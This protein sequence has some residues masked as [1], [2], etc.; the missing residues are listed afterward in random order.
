MKKIPG[1]KMIYNGKIIF[2]KK[3]NNL[4]YHLKII[5]NNF[6]P[7]PGQFINL[8]I[9]ESFQPFLRKPFSIFNYASNKL[10]IIYKVVGKGTEK[11]CLKKPGEI[12]NFIGPLGN[13]YIDFLNEN[14]LNKY[15]YYLIAG[16]SGIASLN[17]LA[18]WLKRKNINFKLFYGSKT[19]NEIIFYNKYKKIDTKF[20]TDDGSAGYKGLITDL[21][22]KEIKNNLIIFA[23]GPESMLHCLSK[24]NFFKSNIKLYA[25]FE[26]YMGCGFGVCLSCVVPVKNNND[27]EYKRVCADG[28]VF[29]LKSL[30]L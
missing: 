19:K 28:P 10:E 17:F 6:N 30:I 2:N 3:I 29:E 5:V 9:D 4:F 14:N 27:F 1:N 16:G 8:L 7:K 26:A 18:N 20:S 23:C 15:N 13:S 24:M 25:S 21:I 12:I 11:L 22:K